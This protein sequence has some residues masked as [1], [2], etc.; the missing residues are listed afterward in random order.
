M[1]NYTI[2]L[3]AFSPR[4]NPGGVTYPKYYNYDTD[5]G[6]PIGVAINGV[7]IFGHHLKFHSNGTVANIALKRN[8]DSCGGH[9]DKKGRY[10]YHGVPLCLLLNM[11]RTIPSTGNKFMYDTNKETQISRWSA[12]AKD[13][14]SPILGFALDGFPIYG[15]Y[16]ENSNL[17]TTSDLDKCNFHAATKRYYFTP[18]YP[19]APTCLVGHRGSYEEYITS[20]SGQSICP[21][22]GIS[23][24][25]CSGPFCKPQSSE[26]DDTSTLTF[27]GALTVIVFVLLSFNV[28]YL[29][30]FL[31]D[32]MSNDQHPYPNRVAALSVLPSFVMLIS[33]PFVMKLFYGVDGALSG[34]FSLD[35]DKINEYLNATVSSYLAVIGVIYSLVVAHLLNMANNKAILIREH[36]V[37]ELAGLKGITQLIKAMPQVNESTKNIK[38]SA[39]ESISSYLGYLDLHWG[40]A[41]TDA[42]DSAVEALDLLYA[43]LPRI[44]P[45]TSTQYDNTRWSTVLVDR[46]IDTI[47]NIGESHYLRLSMEKSHIPIVL[48]IL[49][50]LLST[51]MFFGISLIYTGNKIFN[52]ILCMIGA[53]LIGVSTHA[54]ADL[55]SPYIGFIQLS[56][57]PLM[58]LQ[59]DIVDT[60]TDV[61]KKLIDIETQ[62]QRNRNAVNSHLRS[63]VSSPKFNKML[64]RR[65]QPLSDVQVE[66]GDFEEM[67]AATTAERTQA[68]EV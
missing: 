30:Y 9:G 58:R 50:I 46:M 51:A 41:S 68:S 40:T 14:P 65:D 34:D 17:V 64:S 4:V 3:P 27:D 54:I 11:A 61:D 19:Y 21:K 49:N 26:C 7:L 63:V 5:H 8:F 13:G 33:Y 45:L 56:K 67:R 60:L 42:T 20:G 2:T 43:V 15:P 38:I 6:D 24:T 52:F 10:H 55:D 12:V 16:D 44:G 62:V 22:Q 48:W 53:S 28:I 29:G 47:S 25:Y 66:K 1:H 18:D 36:Y 32:F 31:F 57:V 35:Q 37:K 23:N 39:L 59:A